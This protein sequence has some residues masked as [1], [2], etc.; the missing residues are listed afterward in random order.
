[1]KSKNEND[2]GL[3]SLDFL[4]P[5]DNDKILSTTNTNNNTMKPALT[6]QHCNFEGY[7]FITAAVQAIRVQSV[8]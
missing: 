5:T 8:S 7:N 6:D 1:M 3:H 4:V 2:E